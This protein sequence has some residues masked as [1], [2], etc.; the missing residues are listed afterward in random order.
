MEFALSWMLVWLPVMPARVWP[1]GDRQVKPL[2]M[3]SDATWPGNQEQP[4]ISSC[5]CIAVVLY[6]HRGPPLAFSC[7]PPPDLYAA[8]DQRST[9]IAVL[10]LLGGLL[11]A[12]VFSSFLNRPY[13]HFVDNV[14]AEFI[15]SNGYSKA[16]DLNAL[17]GCF[18]GLAVEKQLAPWFS[19]VASGDNIADDPSRDDWA[20]LQDAVRV[21]PDLSGF[22]SALTMVLRG[23]P[24]PPSFALVRQLAFCSVADPRS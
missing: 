10:E 8:L 22:W 3:Y 11:G 4:I 9:Q 13:V 24:S 23:A 14:G 7:I 15:L 18:W 1:F 16:S 21:V 2:V 19:R 6:D 12:A 17:S 20:S 5:P